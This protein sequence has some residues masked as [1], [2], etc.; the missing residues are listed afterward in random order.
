MILYNPCSSVTTDRT[1]SIR[2]G[3]AASTVT[4]GTT[5]PVVSLTTPAI[6]LDACWADA[7]AGSHISHV[8][9]TSTLVTRFQHMRS[10]SNCARNA[11]HAHERRVLNR[12]LQEQPGKY[13]NAGPL[14]TG[15]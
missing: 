3:L 11:L 5:A 13:T 8:D 4:P 10:S 2:A 9:A 14:A 1:F 12:E 6:A 15:I 7:I